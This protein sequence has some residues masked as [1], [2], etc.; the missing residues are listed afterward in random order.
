MFV[1]ID[2]LYIVNFAL[3]KY[4]DRENIPIINEKLTIDMNK[5][6]TKKQLQYYIIDTLLDNFMYG[7]TNV[8]LNTCNPFNNWRSVNGIESIQNYKY[9][10]E[11]ESVDVNLPL[12]N[13]FLEN[14]FKKIPKLIDNEY[15]YDENDQ[16]LL[17]NKYR[18]FK[19]LSFKD[20]DSSDITCIMKNHYKDLSVM[21]LDNLKYSYSIIKD[22]NT[23]YQH[24]GNITYEI[25]EEIRLTLI[26]KEI[27]YA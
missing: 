13:R 27:I 18:K 16:R 1:F 5:S 17:V 14:I 4:L 25:L 3:L 7:K 21:F 15:Q 12:F 20:I 22:G 24:D 8:I 10:V 19:T 9:I 2:Y 6:T 11:D 23:D 26:E